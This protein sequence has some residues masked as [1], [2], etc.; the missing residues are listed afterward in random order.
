M[1]DY[2]DVGNRVKC[3]TKSGEDQEERED[4]RALRALKE[5]QNAHEGRRGWGHCWGGHSSAACV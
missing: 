1:H 2:P 3:L 5:K 4:G